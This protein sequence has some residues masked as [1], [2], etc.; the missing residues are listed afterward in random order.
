MW[1][2]EQIQRGEHEGWPR[3]LW[4]RSDNLSNSWSETRRWFAMV[5]FRTYTFHILIRFYMLETMRGHFPHLVCCVP[6]VMHSQDWKV[7]KFLLVV[8]MAEKWWL[9]KKNWITLNTQTRQCVQ[10]RCKCVNILKSSLVYGIRQLMEHNNP[11]HYIYHLRQ[12]W[13]KNPNR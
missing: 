3:V 4:S 7:Y 2:R 11:V 5:F 13:S 8:S 6:I 9:G 1:A 12:T 10:N